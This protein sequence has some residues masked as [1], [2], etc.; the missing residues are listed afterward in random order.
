MKTN[1]A[2]RFGRLFA[3]ALV[4]A[5][6]SFVGGTASAA[7]TDGLVQYWDFSQG[8]PTD[9]AVEPAEIVDALSR[10]SAT[11]RT[12]TRID[13]AHPSDA[14]KALKVPGR[15][16]YTN[17][18]VQ[19]PFYGNVTNVRTC[20]WIPQDTVDDNGTTKYCSRQVRLPAPATAENFGKCTVFL[21]FYLAKQNAGVNKVRSLYTYGT[22]RGGTTGWGLT[23]MSSDS[24]LGSLSISH[25]N[26]W[27]RTATVEANGKKDATQG[28][29]FAW[30][31]Q[32][33]WYDLVATVDPSS[34]TDNVNVY[35][36]QSGKW[37]RDPAHSYSQDYQADIYHYRMSVSISAP[38]SGANLQILGGD[39]EVNGWGGGE[40]SSWNTTDCFQ[41]GMWGAFERLMVWNR[42]LTKEEAYDAMMDATGRNIEIGAKND[43]ADEFA[44]TGS[45]TIAD[46][47]DA[48]TMP[49]CRM[50]KELTAANPSLSLKFRVPA[51]EAGL[52]RTLTVDPLLTGTGETV[53]VAATIGSTALNPMDWAKASGCELYIP[54]EL[55]VPDDAGYVTL[56]LT[57]TGDTTG[58]AAIDHLSFGGS[59][60]IGADDGSEPLRESQWLPTVTTYV[61]SLLID[62]LYSNQIV[63]TLYGT[64]S[65]GT[66]Y[67]RHPCKLRF[68]VPSELAANHRSRFTFVTRPQADL[69]DYYPYQAVRIL[70]NGQEI[71]ARDGLKVGANTFD[72]PAGTFAAGANVLEIVNTTDLSAHASYWGTISPKISFAAKRLVFRDLPKGLLLLVR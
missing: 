22:A 23:C 41:H 3:H 21:R 7:W 71:A 27:T 19:I 56:T 1:R 13:G 25:G 6:V 33:R 60:Q 62:D 18:E 24:N 66:C 16:C 53:P 50:R 65:E 30:L 57:R 58:T 69:G 10:G 67:T 45:A 55:A 48:S 64:N 68:V 52:S 72:L 47:Y 49:W 70:V 2:K 42:V 51:R 34:S 40:Q 36:C 8:D 61:D 17:M 54:G 38:A 5:C 63:D 14:T 9:T 28:G 32:G 44:K 35:L 15:V 43:S 46:V 31:A 39:E 29:N 12:A 37:Y 59:W 26:C 20:L 4:V 11:L